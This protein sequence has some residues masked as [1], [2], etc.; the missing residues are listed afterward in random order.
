[1]AAEIEAA[2]IRRTYRLNWR[3]STQVQQKTQRPVQFEIK[4]VAARLSPG[5][6]SKGKAG[7]SCGEKASH[8][9]CSGTNSS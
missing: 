3:A 9:Q 2:M 7:P 1:M 5:R 6:A 8:A 4:T